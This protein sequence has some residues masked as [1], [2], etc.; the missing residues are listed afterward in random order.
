MLPLIY[1]SYKYVFHHIFNQMQKLASYTYEKIA[2]NLV[3]K[4]IRFISDC[5]LFPNFNVSGKI[6][7]LSINSTGE[8]ILKFRV[9]PSGKTITIGSRMRN[10]RFEFL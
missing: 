1:R 8:I 7:S 3:G 10:L 4:P 5:E 2:N 9:K 6:I